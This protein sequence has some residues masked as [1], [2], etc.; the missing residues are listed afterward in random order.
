M[1]LYYS[2]GGIEI[3]HGDAREILPGLR[4]DVVVTDPPYGVGFRGEE[5]D[6]SIPSWW[7]PLARECAPLVVFTTAPTT[8]WDYPRPDW[9]LCAARQASQSRTA[10]GGF[11]HW[12][13][14]LVYGRGAW[15]PD[16]HSAH[17]VH[18]GNDNLGIDHPC[19]KSLALM[20]WIVDGT[21]GSIIDPF[22]GSGTTLRAAKDLGRRAIGIELE[23]RWCELAARR[24]GQEVFPFP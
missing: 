24:M 21:K 11:N 14:V 18:T 9:V 5:W 19:P 2:H 23:E 17:A 3:H 16:F 13:P 10:Y 8:M 12:S 22:M 6:E 1:T 20:R 4:A 7:L 15:S